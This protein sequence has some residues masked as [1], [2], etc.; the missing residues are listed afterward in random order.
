MLLL[1]A[2]EVA[3]LYPCLLTGFARAVVIP[4]SDLVEDV[5]TLLADAA[6]GALVNGGAIDIAQLV[7]AI[8]FQNDVDA[9][10]QVGGTSTDRL[11]VMFAAL[12]HMDVVDGGNLGIPAAGDLGVQEGGGLDVNDV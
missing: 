12:H 8:L 6:G 3:A 5:K 9:I 4:T 1:A 7:G 10:Q 11:Q 2:S